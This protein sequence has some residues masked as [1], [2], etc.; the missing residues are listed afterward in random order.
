MLLNIAKY[1]KTLRWGCVYFFNLLQT[2]IVSEL[3]SMSG[4][5][6]FQTTSPLKPLACFHPN[7]DRSWTVQQKVVKISYSPCFHGNQVPNL[8]SFSPR[9]LSDCISFFRK[10]VLQW[11]VCQIP[12]KKPKP[13]WCL[14]TDLF[15]RCC[16][17]KNIAVVQNISAITFT[18]SLI[19]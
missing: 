2:S 14:V 9:L 11:A 15:S 16:F 6:H 19:L 4:C 12:S 10:I 1:F 7:F 18:I 5:S 3:L 13:Q 8:N 17:L